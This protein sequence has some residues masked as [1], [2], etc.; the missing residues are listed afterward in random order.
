MPTMT[1]AVTWFEI[2]SSDPAATT[3]FY[4]DLFGW[5]FSTDKAYR[6]ISAP[7]EGAIGGGVFPLDGDRPGYGIFYVQVEDVAATVAAA[8]AAGGKVLVPPTGDPGGLIFAHLLDPAGT[9]FG[10]FTPPP[11]QS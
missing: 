6:E 5:T 4:G 10:V 2:G 8:E 7:A 1:N 9:H 3:R 11:A